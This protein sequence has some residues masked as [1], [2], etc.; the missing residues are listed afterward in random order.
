M[1]DENFGIMCG[2]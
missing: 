1:K 2:Q